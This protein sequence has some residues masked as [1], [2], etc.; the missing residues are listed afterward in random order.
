MKSSPW[1][2]AAAAVA[3]VWLTGTGN[4]Q[5]AAGKAGEAQ[6]TAPAETKPQVTCPVMGG[7]ANEKV[8]VDVKG[9]R[10]YLCC[11]GCAAKVKEDPDKYLAKI[12]ENGQTV[13]KT[14]PAEKPAQSQGSGETAKTAA[15]GCCS[16]AGAAPGQ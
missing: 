11:E 5:N 16:G 12:K 15:G 1:K 3:L 4:A 6:V 9:F 14:P 2:A 10:V 13:A 8:F 7:K